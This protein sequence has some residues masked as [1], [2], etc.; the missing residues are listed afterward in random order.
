MHS[1]KLVFPDY[2][3][4]IVNLVSS[5]LRGYGVNTALNGLKQLDTDKLKTKKNIILLILDGFGLNLFEK[6]SN[7]VCKT[8]GKFDYFPITS[9]FPSTTSAAITSLLTCSTPIEHGVIGWTLYFKEFAKNIDFL[10]NW[11]SITTTTQDPNKYNVYDY[12]G[13]ECIFK[14]IRDVNKDIGNYHI[15]PKSIANSTNTQKVSEFASL[16]T[17]KNEKQLFKQLYKICKRPK[18]RKNFIYAYSSCPD[19]Y[20]HQEGVYSEKVKNYLEEIDKN[21]NKFLKK[22][23]LRK[24]ALFITADHG[25]IDINHY[26]YVNEDKVLFDSLILPTF[27]EPRFI[28]FFVKS[29]KID[30][31]KRSISKYKD[32]FVIMNRDEF[33]ESKLLGEETPHR[34]IDDFVGN[35]IAIAKSDK[36]LKSIYQQN[37][38]WKKEFKAHHA[39]L[40]SDEMLVPLIKIGL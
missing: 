32:D 2:N 11:D 8:I 18:N 24:T 38:K 40:T 10:P 22:I 30:Q 21:L 31:F 33:F 1:S 36:A 6:Y 37:G 15:A 19:K 23:D 5:I 39:G 7:T 35:Y 16:R 27:P 29:H 17:H 4:S 12:L 28:S 9:V 26:H 14:K 13:K 20:E 3:N 34:K 25:L